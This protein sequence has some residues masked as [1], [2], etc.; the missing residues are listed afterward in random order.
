MGSE[1]YPETAKLAVEAWDRG[2]R[3]WTVDMS[4]M[5]SGYEGSIQL[6]MF[7]LLRAFHSHPIITNRKEWTEEEGEKAMDDLNKET[8]K[9]NRK[10]QLGLSGAQAG[11][12]RAAAIKYSRWGYRHMVEKVEPDR[13]IEADK[14]ILDR[15]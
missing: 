6:T 11:E 10:F 1:L 7:E 5:G 3:V 13:R 4:G 12:A 15:A 9:I 8:L 14:K 2:E